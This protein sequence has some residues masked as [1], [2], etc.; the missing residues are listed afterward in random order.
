MIDTTVLVAALSNIISWVVTTFLPSSCLQYLLPKSPEEDTCV[1]GQ[2]N[3]NQT[4]CIS[5]GRPGGMEQLRLI[6]LRE[7]ICTIGY[8][9]KH[10]RKICVCIVLS[11]EFVKSHMY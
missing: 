4:Q 3:T 10:V 9:V 5:I 8:N 1:D 2:T 7:G 11:Y 6:T